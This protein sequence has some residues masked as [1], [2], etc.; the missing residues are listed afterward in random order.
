MDRP[1]LDFR[2]I[3]LQALPI[4]PKHVIS[5]R[6]WPFTPLR[7]VAVSKPIELADYV[8]V[9]RLPDTFYKGASTFSE[10]IYMLRAILQHLHATNIEAFCL[11]QGKL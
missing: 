7:T 10:S 8:I 5:T 11:E 1:L 4:P 9:K 6:W 2:S 3:P